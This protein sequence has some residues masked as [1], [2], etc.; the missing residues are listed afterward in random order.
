LGYTILWRVANVIS[1]RLR[2]ARAQLLDMFEP[3]RGDNPLA[4]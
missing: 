4:T 2:A 1:D 3:S